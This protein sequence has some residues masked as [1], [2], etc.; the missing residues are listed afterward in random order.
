MEISFIVGA[1]SLL[2][3]VVE[4]AAIFT[5]IVA[6]RETRTPQGAVAW[7][8]SLVTFPWVS[9][10]LYWIF[11]RTK[12]NGYVDAMRAGKTE[13]D[14]LIGNNHEVPAVRDLS[15]RKRPHAPRKIGRASCR[16]R[17]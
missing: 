5:A 10:P 8:V 1:F 3:T 7:A 6:V 14:Q 12:F 13:F 9:L 2:Y 4:I 17:V 11:G 15:E 16:E